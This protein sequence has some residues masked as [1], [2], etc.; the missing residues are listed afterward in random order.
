MRPG[1][2]TRGWPR[3][4]GLRH[5]TYACQICC[6]GLWQ[7]AFRTLGYDPDRETKHDE[8]RHPP[9]QAT[10]LHVIIARFRGVRIL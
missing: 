4:S 3:I 8:G 7:R 10:L 6:A 9:R 2:F 5:L 1:A